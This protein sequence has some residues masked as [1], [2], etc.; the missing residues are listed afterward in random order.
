MLSLPNC[1]STSTASGEATKRPIVTSRGRP[2]RSTVPT[3]LKSA[4]SADSYAVTTS[5]ARVS[6]SQRG[7]PAPGPGPGLPATSV[8]KSDCSRTP[9]P[10]V[11]M[12]AAYQEP[13][14][15][16]S[17]IMRPAL[18][19]AW[20]S[21]CAATRATRLP[22]PESR[23]C[24][25]RPWSWMPGRRSAGAAPPPPVPGAWDVSRAVPDA[26]SRATATV[27]RTQASRVIT[28][29]GTDL[30]LVHS[31]SRS[32]PKR[33]PPGATVLRYGVGVG[34]VIV[35]PLRYGRSGRS[36]RWRPGTPRRRG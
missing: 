35:P 23:W 5:P 7:A 6:F 31:D 34:V 22:S 32:R 17:R 29:R 9:W 21:S 20:L 15:V 18:A 1:R 28:Q 24:S 4:P 10:G 13:G 26:A 30:S 33:S 3:R 36:G 14:S 12:T 2:S 19:Q 27:R 11:S 25:K 16:P 8:V